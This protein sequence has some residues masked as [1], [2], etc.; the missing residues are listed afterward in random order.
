[1]DSCQSDLII[2]LPLEPLFEVSPELA[3][4]F[5][6]TIN[7]SY[8]DLS[9]VPTY[10]PS[11]SPSMHSTERKLEQPS[12][13]N[14]PS[15]VDSYSNLSPT[16]NPSNLISSRS[17]C[18]S[19]LASGHNST[20]QF[21]TPNDV[22]A[23]LSSSGTF[24]STPTYAPPSSSPSL[25]QSTERRPE[26]PPSFSSTNAP[27]ILDPYS[28]SSPTTNP[29]NLASLK[30][31]WS[32]SAFKNTFGCDAT[33][34][35]TNINGSW[36]NQASERCTKFEWSPQRTPKV[37]YLPN[38]P[39]STDAPG[40]NND[41]SR[42][43]SINEEVAKLLE[44]LNFDITVPFEYNSNAS[45]KKVEISCES[46]EKIIV[47]IKDSNIPDPLCDVSTI[48]FFIHHEST[49]K[50][51]IPLQVEVFTANLKVQFTFNITATNRHASE[52][53]D[54]VNVYGKYCLHEEVLPDYGTK[55]PLLQFKGYKKFLSKS[56]VF[57]PTSPNIKEPTSSK[58]TNSFKPE[59]FYELRVYEISKPPSSN[60]PPNVSKTK[61]SGMKPPYLDTP[62]KKKNAFIQYYYC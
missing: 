57:G 54:S 12:F 32:P 33:P 40:T 8:P 47:S 52:N 28:N 35:P 45:C 18:N 62:I 16:T 10:A 29:S 34:T 23:D 59:E 9:S 17:P 58:N 37:R 46:F 48:A 50:K 7:P 13:T 60:T 22:H 19:S 30:S 61:S 14:A 6:P 5:S 39:S 20:E 21:G 49:R 2:S 4:M 42:L 38:Q 11:N 31:S 51:K 25:L 15:I 36:S 27:S 53:F 26:K 43:I 1:M 56:N 3:D 44:S 41:L 24:G 55:T